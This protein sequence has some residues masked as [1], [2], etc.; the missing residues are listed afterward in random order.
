MLRRTA[1]VLLLITAI[2]AVGQEQ[3]RWSFRHRL[4][5]RANYRDSDE[6]R[7]QLRFP[8]PPEMLR[9]GRTA[10]FLET[11]DPGSHGEL[12]VVSL[13]LDAAY[14]DWFAARAKVHVQ[15]KYRRNPTSGDKQVDAEE[16]FVRIGPKPEFL[17][18]PEGTSFFVQVGKAPKMERQPLR[19]LESYGVA[20]TAFNRFEDL[21]VL[22]GG[23]I[24]RNF[25][26]RVQ[27]ANGNPLYFRDTNALAGDNGVRELL[28]PNP[29]PD[30]NS[31]FPILYNAE[32]EGW[33]FR[34]DRLQLG[35]GLGYRWQNAARDLG[36][37]LIVFHYRRTLEDEANLTGTFYGG[38]LDLLDGVG[39]ISL[40]V[41]SREKKEYGG[42]L[43][44]EWREG[45]FI[46]QFTKQNIAGLQREGIEGEV[47]YRLPLSFGPRVGVEPLIQS[48]QPAVRWSELTNRF[49]GPREFVAPSVWWNWKKLDYGVRIAFAKNADLTIERSRHSISAPGKPA[50]HETL[51]TLRVRV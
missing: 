11:V 32:A 24:G 47:G 25:Y 14:G 22:S 20:A 29:D 46:A 35:E 51:V 31:G 39:G 16:L 26:W 37:D 17:D 13:Q 23:T 36:F 30:L 45:T 40:P 48:I 49:R 3:E 12:S 4:E 38:D 5:I 33:G 34:T 28:R 43:Y 19:L 15:D 6:A 44:A 8:F 7:F 18:R 9:P 27:V 1:I 42:R 21:Q 41:T 50:P 10:G 2:P